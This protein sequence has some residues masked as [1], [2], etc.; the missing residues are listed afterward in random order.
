M[1]F[2]PS[3]FNTNQ[4]ALAA[5]AAPATSIPIPVETTTTQGVSV[6]TTTPSPVEPGYSTTEFWATVYADVTAL[7]PAIT[8]HL[9]W[10]A[11]SAIIGGVSAIYGIA[12][13]FRKAGT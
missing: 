13:S 6:S 10:A 5:A 11:A 3:T 4:A 7:V 8:G 1:A 12:R 2:D 9:S